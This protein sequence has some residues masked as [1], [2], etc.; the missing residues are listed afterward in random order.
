MLKLDQ[1]QHLKQE[2]LLD[3]R[4]SLTHIHM[5]PD[6]NDTRLKKS[7]IRNRHDNIRIGNNMAVGQRW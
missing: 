7:E 5:N 4:I 2:K 3:N 1:M 6:F